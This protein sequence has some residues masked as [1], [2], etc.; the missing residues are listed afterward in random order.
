MTLQLKFRAIGVLL[1]SFIFEKRFHIKMNNFNEGPTE[2]VEHM[3][4]YRRIFADIKK[5]FTRMLNSQI[6][7]SKIQKLEN[8]K[9]T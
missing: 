9:N 4:I 2:V 3:Q 1:L 6:I 8:E 7:K 5:E